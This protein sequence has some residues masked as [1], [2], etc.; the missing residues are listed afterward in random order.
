MSLADKPD[1]YKKDP[2]GRRTGAAP[3]E[4]AANT[5]RKTLE[6][7]YQAVNKVSKGYLERM[8]CPS[9]PV[10]REPREKRVVTG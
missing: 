1:N 9:G 6:D 5:L 7:A 8:C 3:V 4:V 10:D 2:T